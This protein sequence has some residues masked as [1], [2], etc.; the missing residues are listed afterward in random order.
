MGIQRTGAFLVGCAFVILF[1][2]QL[3][4]R[5]VEDWP[6]DKLFKHADLVIIAKATAVREARKE[7]HAVP[8]KRHADI[9]TG[10]VTSFKVLQVIKGEY[11]HNKMDLVHFRL[12]KGVEILNGPLLVKFHTKHTQ[13]SGNGWSGFAG[14]TYMLFLKKERAGRF[15]PVSGQFDPAESV[16]QILPPLPGGDLPCQRPNKAKTRKEAN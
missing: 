15:E 14:N 7:D 1:C 9:L 11:K 13:L 4:A 6:Y 16:K 8:P 3:R 5:Q 10:V 2:S 12:K